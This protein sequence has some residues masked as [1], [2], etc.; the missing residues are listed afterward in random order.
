MKFL[1]KKAWIFST[2]FHLTIQQVSSPG[3][4]SSDAVD[5]SFVVITGWICVLVAVEVRQE[6]PLVSERVLQT[7]RTQRNLRGEVLEVAVV[8]GP[9][10]AL[11]HRPIGTELALPLRGE[12]PRQRDRLAPQHPVINNGFTSEHCKPTRR[13]QRTIQKIHSNSKNSNWEF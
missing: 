12:V 13:H 6:A 5:G 1:K 9:R 7:A 11:L 4:P 10:V 8:H 3:G 2:L